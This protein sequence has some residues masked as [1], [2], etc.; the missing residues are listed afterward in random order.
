MEAA[1]TLLAN[2]D[3]RRQ[4]EEEMA[5]IPVSDVEVHDCKVEARKR[6]HLVVVENMEELDIAVAIEEEKTYFSARHA[7]LAFLVVGF[8]LL[9][10][11]SYL[12]LQ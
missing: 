8:L 1:H 7:L 10:P 11:R 5:H 12:L 4:L 2:K 3:T 6:R 9:L